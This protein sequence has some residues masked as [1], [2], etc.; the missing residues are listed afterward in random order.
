MRK[1]WVKRGVRIAMMAIVAIP[2]IGFLVMSLWNWL[3]PA[4]FGARTIDFWQAWGIILLS[5]LLFGGFHGRPGYRGRWKR[6]MRERWE[7][8]T[9]EEREK[10][11]QGMAGRC[12][13]AAPGEA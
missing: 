3:A 2:A 6:R 1:R 4:V 13:S 10:F 9:P 8:M 11:L 12:G 5:K 7:R